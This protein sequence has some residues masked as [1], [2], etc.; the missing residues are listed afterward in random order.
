[1]M[2]LGTEFSVPFSHSWWILMILHNYLLNYFMFECELWSFC[3]DSSLALYEMGVLKSQ[4]FFIRSSYRVF[5]MTGQNNR[6]SLHYTFAPNI[7]YQS[8]LTFFAYSVFG[9]LFSR[10]L[11]FFKINIFDNFF[12]EYHQSVKQFGSRSG[13]TKCPAWSG[14]K[15]FA[16]VIT[17]RQGV[18]RLCQINSSTDFVF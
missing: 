8:F 4:L 16:K 17:R 7:R 9:M 3:R 13:R 6:N 2:I 14:S 11:I 10:L 1:M 12:Q 5:G 18:N 15:L